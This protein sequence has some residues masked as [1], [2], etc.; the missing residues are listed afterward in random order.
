M[1]RRDC[2][3]R[4]APAVVL[5]VALLAGCS[6]RAEQTVAP[7][8]GSTVAQEQAKSPAA[9]GLKVVTLNVKGM[10]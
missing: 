9:P 1:Q 2:I 4:V 3:E 6:E 5:A 7:A 10:H 8:G